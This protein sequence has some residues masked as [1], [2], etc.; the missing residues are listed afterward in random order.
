MESL[1]SLLQKNALDCRSSATREEPRIAIV[2]W[3]ERTY[4]RRYR[5]DALG[6]LTPLEC[7][8]IMTTPATQA[9]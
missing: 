2:T 9:A 3:V 5:Q 6:R 1:F 7:E 4:H 8:T